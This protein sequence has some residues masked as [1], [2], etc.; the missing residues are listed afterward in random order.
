[1][2]VGG[3]AWNGVRGEFRPQPGSLRGTGRRRNLTVERN[4]APRAERVGVVALTRGSR[5]GAEVRKICGRARHHIIVIAR[6]GPRARQVPA[7]GWRV[8]VPE[9]LGAATR[10]GV[11]SGGEHCAL[12]SIEQSRGGLTARRSALGDVARADEHFR[13]ERAGRRRSA[14][15]WRRRSRGIARA[16]SSASGCQRN[17]YST[18]R[19]LGRCRESRINLLLRRRRVKQG[20]ALAARLALMVLAG[21][22]YC[23][24]A[25]A[26]AIQ[27]ETRST[28]S[29]V[30][31]EQSA[32]QE[33]K[34]PPVRLTWDNR[35]SLRF[36]EF[37]RIDFRVRLQADARQ[38]SVPLEPGESMFSWARKRVGVDGEFGRVFSFQIERELADADDPWRDV[39]IDYGPLDQIHVQAGKFK[40]PFSLD[41][42][43]AASNLDFV[44]RSRAADQ[45]APGRDRGVMV[46][47]RVVHRFWSTRSACSTM[48]AG[49]RVGRPAIASRADA[50]SLAGSRRSRCERHGRRDVRW[51]SVPPW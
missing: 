35:P 5:A 33:K 26:Q 37:A 12:Q 42:N 18:H 22:L 29:S 4:H 13:D 23:V 28:Q 43:T 51:S 27:P 45:L 49:I 24:P 50:R 32:V 34:R 17:Q 41:Q 7:P 15:L 44:Y 48:T 19:V 3:R 31:D 10:I 11:V 21:L 40:L 16:R 25:I 30:V 9:I 2:P 36:G 46:H 47:G 6:H 8:T 39:F 1:M 20:V 14:G 38:S